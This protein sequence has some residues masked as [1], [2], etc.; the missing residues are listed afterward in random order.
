M[1]GAEAPVIYAKIQ[2]RQ[3]PGFRFRLCPLSG[4]ARK[5]KT[6]RQK[7]FT[8]RFKLKSIYR[9]STVLI[10]SPQCGARASW[11]F[12]RYGSDK[13]SIEAEYQS[14]LWSSVTCKPLWSSQQYFRCPA[15]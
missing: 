8:Q 12:L 3:K 1:G 5:K 10:G 13:L 9:S 14:P 15:R 6:A 2:L 4:T 7:N 11:S